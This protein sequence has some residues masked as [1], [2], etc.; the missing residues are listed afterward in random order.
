MENFQRAADASYVKSLYN[1]GIIHL[2]GEIGVQD[3]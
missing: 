1:L 3:L 2:Q